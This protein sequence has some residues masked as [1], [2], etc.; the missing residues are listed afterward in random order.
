MEI[1]LFFTP[2]E[3]NEFIPTIKLDH[4]EAFEGHYVVFYKPYLSPEEATKKKAQH[5]LK[6][7]QKDLAEA[8]LH[9]K[10]LE[11]I[12][13]TAEEPEKVES[14]IKNTKTNIINYKATIEV[15][16]EYA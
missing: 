13:E 2:E 6:E 14:G 11:K 9:L 10:V 12:K 1:K 16:S 8:E 5:D 4:I 7:A 3:V 15:L